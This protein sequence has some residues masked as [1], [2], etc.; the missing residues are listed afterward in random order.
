MSEHRSQIPQPPPQSRI[1]QATLAAAPHGVDAL[2]RFYVDDFGLAG[3]R[4]HERLQ[5]SVGAAELR[6]DA[7]PSAGDPFYHFA[8]LVPGN[9][10]VA[11]RDWLATHVP[12]LARAESE[13]TV[14]EFDFWNAR[15]CYAHDP[16]GNIVEL[17]AH[18]DVEE[19]AHGGEFSG[20]EL[21]G[22][23]ELGLVTA[24]LLMA[25]ERLRTHGLELWSGEITGVREGFGFVGRKAD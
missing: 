13:E 5:L 10:F 1:R 22:I 25:L 18:Q 24:D 17:I 8:L 3:T 6:F 16:E 2:E 12:L 19:S 11:A 20:A 9:R 21:L 4:E 15:A 7:R 14:F 23:S